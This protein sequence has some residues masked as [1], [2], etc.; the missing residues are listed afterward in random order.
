[1][2]VDEVRSA[3]TLTLN[4]RSHDSNTF[5][6]QHMKE[7]IVQKKKEVAAEVGLDPSITKCSVSTEWAKIGVTVTAAESDL[8]LSKK[9]LLTKTALRYQSE[10]SVM[11]GYSYA[12]TCI[13]T[14]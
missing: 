1:M 9:K 10:H 14:H 11:R 5:G 4:N 13:M 12:L 2:S 7:M 3:T 6:L 8:S